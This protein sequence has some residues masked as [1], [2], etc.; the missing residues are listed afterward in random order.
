MPA[1]VPAGDRHAL[2]G[3]VHHQAVAEVD[4]RVADLL[5]RGAPSAVA[6]Q[7]HVAGLHRRA[8]QAIA[9]LRRPRHVVGRAAAHHG[10]QPGGRGGVVHEDPH[11]EAGAVEA[12]VHLQ[13]AVGGSGLLPLAGPDVGLADQ[14]DGRLQGGV[15]G[16]GGGGHAGDEAPGPTR[17][18]R[19]PSPTSPARGPRSRR[20]RRGWRPPSRCARARRCRRG[21]CSG[22]RAAGRRPRCRRR[23]AGRSRR[24]AAR[25][26]PRRPP[27]RDRR[28]APARRRAGRWS[29]RC[30]RR[31]RARPGR[32][33]AAPRRAGARGWPSRAARR[34]RRSRRSRRAAA[35]AR[36]P[37][38][39]PSRPTRGAGP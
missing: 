11:H 22:G 16:A 5:P 39:C 36:R 34:G 17:R 10:R 2:A 19:P 35:R 27:G 20:R 3:R 15:A 37:G 31:A 21:G 13:L 7:Q 12:P 14:A 23:P 29:A 4:A 30:G 18:W 24:C 32:P 26:S 9:L 25:R 28:R 38:R 6:E 8:G 1:H 33:G